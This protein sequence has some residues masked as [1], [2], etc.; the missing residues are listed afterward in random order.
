MQDEIAKRSRG[1]RPVHRSVRLCVTHSLIAFNHDRCADC[2][3][4]GRQIRS[5]LRLS[6]KWGEILKGKTCFLR[7]GN[8]LN[9]GDAIYRGLFRYPECYAKFI[10]PYGMST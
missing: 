8:A 1:W 7:L 3:T 5:T 2:A 4:A 10:S 9:C 6:S